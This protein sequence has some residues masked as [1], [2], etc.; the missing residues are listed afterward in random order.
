MAEIFVVMV[1]VRTPGT[2]EAEAEAGIETHEIPI[3][4]FSTWDAAEAA[5]K[6][7]GKVLDE[8]MYIPTLIYSFELDNASDVTWMF[9]QLVKFGGASH[10]T[11]T[12]HRRN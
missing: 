3:G 9:E 6:E 11:H 7:A 8:G 1:D 4:I 10:T 12:T 5:I 2:A